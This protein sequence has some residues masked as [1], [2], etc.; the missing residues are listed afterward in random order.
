MNLTVSQSD[1]LDL[2]RKYDFYIE[3]NIEMGKWWS[4]H[5]LENG[6]VVAQ[7]N[8]WKN[9]LRSR[10]EFEYDKFKNIRQETETY[11]LDDGKVNKVSQVKLKYKDG[12]L[13][14]KELDYGVTENYSDF[15]EFGKPKLI[16]RIVDEPLKPLSYKELIEYDNHGNIAKST[17]YSIYEDFDGKTSNEIAITYY[18]YDARNNV[19]EIRR[20]FQPKRDFPIPIT[21]GPSLYEL[22]Y[23]RYKYNKDGLWTKKYKTVDGKE[24]LIKKRIYK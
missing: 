23:F 20:E 9:E 12:Q 1:K 19:I 17:E 8:F 14:R 7:E 24:Y 10:Y 2:L 6:L 3:K 22:E 21:G 11:N 15:N 4:K 16:E 13:V 5:V 18:K